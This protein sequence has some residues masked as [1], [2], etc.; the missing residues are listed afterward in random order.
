MKEIKGMEK[1]SY[2]FHPFYLWWKILVAAREA[3]AL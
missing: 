2:R 3:D 1:K